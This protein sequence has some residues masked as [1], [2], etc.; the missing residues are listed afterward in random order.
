MKKGK[1]KWR[2]KKNVGFAVWKDTKQVNVASTAFHPKE[3]RTCNR[4]QKDG[5]KKSIKCPLL[6]P[7]YTKRM[8]G[9]DRFDQKRTSY[10]VGR[11]SRKWW[12]R[13]FYFLIDV[14]ITNDYYIKRTP[15]CTML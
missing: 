11:R 1:W 7:E 8:G 5:S 3:K 12:P 2:V 4:T 6:I 9:V 15:E 14:A 10:A 13:I